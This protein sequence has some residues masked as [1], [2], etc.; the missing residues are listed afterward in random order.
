MAKTVALL[1]G[2]FNQGEGKRPLT[3]FQKELKAMT[4]EEKKKLA[5]E[6]AAVTGQTCDDC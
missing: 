2:Y 4:P 6:V 3:E 1:A 5:G